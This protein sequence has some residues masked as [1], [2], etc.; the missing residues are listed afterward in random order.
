[1]TDVQPQ[2]PAWPLWKKIALRFF[3]VYFFF[4][5]DPVGFLFSYLDNIKWV[6]NVTQYVTQYYSQF[7]DWMVNFS[8]SH[9]FH[10]RPVLVPPNG[11]GDTSYGWTN[12]WM[13]LTLAFI[14]CI[15][16][17][18]IDRKRRSYNTLNYWLC[19]GVRYFVAIIAFSYGIIKLFALQMP[20]PNMHQLATPLGDFLPMRLSWMFIGYSTP[21]QMFSGIMEVIAGALLLYRRTATMGALFALAV[22]VN[23]MMLN[24]TYDIPVKIFSMQLVFCCMFLVAE[25]INRILCFFVLNK[26]VAACSV[27]NYSYNKKW[28][29]VVRILAKLA[30]VY[31]A[32]IAPFKQSYDRYEEALEPTKKQPVS[33][34]VYD[35]TVYTVNNNPQPLLLSDTLR[36][37]DV[38]FQD[39][40]GSI[41][42][43][44]TAFRQRYKRGYFSYGLDSAT[45]QL[46]FKNPLTNNLI[47]SFTFDMPDSTTIHLHGKQ[48]GDSLFVELKR[49]KRNF[50]LAERQFHWLS[51]YNR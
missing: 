12:L 29:R 39:G 34:G 4:Q 47:S 11:S 35:V 49:V 31:F 16:W 22:F 36:W 2:Q 30:I 45:N 44:D 43:A 3:V 17:S 50:Q 27:Y 25:D 28:Q 42:T 46:T 21:Y 13:I 41:K 9:F 20:F 37:R 6:G 38:I 14:G 24:L 1:M 48:H 23:V 5:V 7:Q 19:L 8:N 18:V 26:P 10:V 51:E 40:L 15:V 32:V 33:N